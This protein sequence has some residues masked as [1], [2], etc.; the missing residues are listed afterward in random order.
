MSTEILIFGTG[1]FPRRNFNRVVD[2]F[3]AKEDFDYPVTAIFFADEDWSA[4]TDVAFDYVLE[5]EYFDDNPVVLCPTSDVADEKLVEDL[6]EEG[7]SVERYDD[8]YDGVLERT[9]FTHAMCLFDEEDEDLAEDV[10]RLVE[11]GRVVYDVI[12]GM[13]E[14]DVAVEDPEDV[15]PEHE[16]DSPAS[17]DSP[18]SEDSADDDETNDGD[19]HPKVRVALDKLH[20]ALSN[21]DDPGDIDSKALATKVG[22]S[23]MKKVLDHLGIER[24]KG[25]HTKT[26]VDEVLD[27]LY[28]DLAAPA[29]EDVEDTVEEPESVDS[30][31]S[32]DSPVSED[33]PE[34][35]EEAY[36]EDLDVS[37]AGEPSNTLAARPAVAHVAFADIVALLSVYDGDVDKARDAAAA[38]G[39]TFEDAR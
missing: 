21:A 28:E 22:N 5:S 23:A 13:L 19:L 36:P 14:F 37:V 18:D 35:A 24:Y 39:V 10:M 32:V 20:E 25:M 30:V 38:F 33:S 3:F 12:G 11:D 8:I 4:T 31:E 29:E 7:A 6:A 2:E 26:M 34:E 27:L 17:V 1:E 16:E 15:E 9:D